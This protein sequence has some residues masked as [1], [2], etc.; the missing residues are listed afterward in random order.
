[1]RIVWILSAIIQQFLLMQPIQNS[2]Q[3]GRWEQWRAI[4]QEKVAVNLEDPL[5]SKGYFDRDQFVFEFSKKFSRLRLENDA[6]RPGL[7]WASL[8]VEENIAVQSLNLILIDRFSGRRI[9][10]KL[11]FFLRKQ[12]EWKLYYLRGLNL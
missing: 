12:K 8:Q 5:A 1:M 6:L 7:E 9:P 4:C 3:Q 2:L 11:I 10:Y